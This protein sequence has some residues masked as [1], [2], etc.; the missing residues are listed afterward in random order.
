M[1]LV[2]TVERELLDVVDELGEVSEA[3]PM[4]A[5]TTIMMTMAIEAALLIP[6]RLCDI[7]KG[8]C[9]HRIGNDPLVETSLPD[10]F[11]YYF[12]IF[13]DSFQVDSIA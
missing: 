4:N 12:D 5:T 2:L 11:A 9:D 7:S 13:P 6:L 3:Y 10:I 8:I 1:P